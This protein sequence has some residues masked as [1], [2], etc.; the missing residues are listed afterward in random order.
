MKDRS[1]ALDRAQVAEKMGLKRQ[2]V[3]KALSTLEKKGLLIR[4]EKIGNHYK[5]SSTN[6]KP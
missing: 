1:E 5:W 2:Q 6:K 3:S 4:G